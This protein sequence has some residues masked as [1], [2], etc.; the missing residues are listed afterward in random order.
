MMEGQ[1]FYTREEAASKLGL[2]PRQF[3]KLVRD[4]N[5]EFTSLSTNGGPH[6]EGRTTWGMTQSQIDALIAA[7]ARRV[8]PTHA[9]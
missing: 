3:S 2:S 5:A 1:S 9:Q 4:T 8:R 7:R 6:Q